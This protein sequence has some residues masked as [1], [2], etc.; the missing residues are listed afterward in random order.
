MSK[1]EEEGY[2]GKGPKIWQ[3]AEYDSLIELLAVG[4]CADPETWRNLRYKPT[5]WTGAAK[6]TKSQIKT[7]EALADIV[8]KPSP[9]AASALMHP[10]FSASDIFGDKHAAASRA[11]STSASSKEDAHS[12]LT[13]HMLAAIVKEINSAVSAMPKQSEKTKA[14]EG[15]PGPAPATQAGRHKASNARKKANAR[16]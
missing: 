5:E 6:V 9:V 11:S 14:N 1:A 8:S 4:L 12:K 16:K 2:F 10:I 3:E 7:L 13:K 15:E